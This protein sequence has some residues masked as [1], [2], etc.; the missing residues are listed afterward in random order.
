[1]GSIKSG[2][3]MLAAG[4]IATLLTIAWIWL[5]I[6]AKNAPVDPREVGA[7]TEPTK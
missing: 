4:I 3:I 1:M 2:Y 6:E 5:Y 7:H